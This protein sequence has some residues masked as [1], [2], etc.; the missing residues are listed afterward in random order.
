MADPSE[1]RT[2][3]IIEDEESVRSAIEAGLEVFG[4]YEVHSASEAIEGYRLLKELH[5][6]IL[7]LDLVMPVTDGMEFLRLMGTDPDT[8]KPGKV[9]LMTAMT[10]PVPQ[11]SM[12]EL[13]LDL[14]LEKPFRLH[15]LADAVGA[16]NPF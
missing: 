5:P 10:N 2:V 3:L 11:G 16:E 9:V 4:G 7:L 6:D 12:K 13:G 14:I 8:A 15:Q 1:V